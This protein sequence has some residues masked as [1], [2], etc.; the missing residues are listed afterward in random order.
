MMKNYFMIALLFLIGSLNSFATTHGNTT[1]RGIVKAFDSKTLEL[2][3]EKKRVKVP[4]EY[5]SKDIKL[6]TVPLF[7]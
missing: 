2:K 5:V 4:R 7:C 1:L 3:V 6:E